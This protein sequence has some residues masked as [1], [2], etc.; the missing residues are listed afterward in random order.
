M[1]DL[2]RKLLLRLTKNARTPASDLARDLGVSRGTVQNRIDKLTHLGVIERFTVELGHRNGEDQVSAF[3]LVH[4]KASDDQVV[5]ASLKRIAE[6]AQVS[7]LSGGFD[8]VIELR[9][10]SLERLDTVLDNIRTLPDVA[11]TQSHIRLRTWVH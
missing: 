7:S 6:V 10:D 11:D 5:R 9:C 3:A 2:D 1:D 4:T 8:L